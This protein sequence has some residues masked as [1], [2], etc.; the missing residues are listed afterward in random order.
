MRPNNL[1]RFVDAETKLQQTDRDRSSRRSLAIERTTGKV[2]HRTNGQSRELD[3][4]DAAR[5]DLRPLSREDAVRPNFHH[6]RSRLRRGWSGL[7]C[8][9]PPCFRARSK[10]NTTVAEVR[11]NSRAT[12]G[13]S[14]ATAAILLASAKQASQTESDV[15]ARCAISPARNRRLSP[16]RRH[17]QGRSREG[18]PAHRRAACQT[19]RPGRGRSRRRILP[20]SRA[21]VEGPGGKP[22]ARVS[23]AGVTPREPRRPG[24]PRPG[25]EWL[26]ETVAVPSA[27]WLTTAAGAGEIT[28]PVE[29]AMGATPLGIARIDPAPTSAMPD[30]NTGAVMAKP[31]AEEIRRSPV[32]TIALGSR[33]YSPEVPPSAETST[34]YVPP[35]VAVKVIS[36][37]RPSAS[38][39]PTIVAPSGVWR[40]KSGFRLLTNAPGPSPGVAVK[41]SI[42][43]PAAAVNE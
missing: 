33:T 26:R 12:D 36:S 39:T 18:T 20:R 8:R 13:L 23:S 19:A 15:A 21:P 34:M 42:V 1:V 43:S 29:G 30:A 2:E 11:V 5:P 9:F 14:S 4:V 41:R 31:V 28:T 35:T 32:A 25:A 38:A 22:T 7:A 6:G 10:A 37:L 16:G 24:S 17:D 3:I 40:I 27:G